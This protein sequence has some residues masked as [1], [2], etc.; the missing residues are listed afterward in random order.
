VRNVANELRPQR[1]WTL[2]CLGLWLERRSECLAS[3]S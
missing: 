3:L 2:L 1:K